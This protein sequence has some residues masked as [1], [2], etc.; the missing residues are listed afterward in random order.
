MKI[1]D[2]FELKPGQAVPV[3]SELV[4]AAASVSLE[5]INGESEAQQ[6][7]A[8]QLLPSGALNIST[9]KRGSHGAGDLGAIDAAEA[10]R[11]PALGEH[12]DRW[13]ENLL[14][15]YLIVVVVAGLLERLPGA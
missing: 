15:V 5:W 13:L 1:G 10:A 4:D 7:T 9:R 8:G 11:R 2:R 14:R 12:R 3:A 6:R